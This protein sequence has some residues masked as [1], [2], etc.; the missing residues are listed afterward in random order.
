MSEEGMSCTSRFRVANLSYSG[1][2]RLTDRE[3]FGIVLNHRVEV[4]S[5]RNAQR[6]TVQNTFGLILRLYIEGL[7]VFGTYLDSWC[8]LSDI[9]NSNV[10]VSKQPR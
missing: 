4:V 7:Q 10:T 9:Q 6:S 8:S 1:S 3:V 2:S 5:H